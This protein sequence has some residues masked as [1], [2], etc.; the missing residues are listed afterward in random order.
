M[1]FLVIKPWDVDVK[2][3]RIK[4]IFELKHSL[5]RRLSIKLALVSIYVLQ[6]YKN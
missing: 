4:Y 1:L 2:F 5:R 6:S 3:S